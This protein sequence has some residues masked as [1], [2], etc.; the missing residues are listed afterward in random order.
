MKNLLPSEKIYIKQS[1]IPKAGRGI[2]A[3]DDIEKG[4]VIEV[5]PVIEISE[6]DASNVKEG[7]LTTYIYYSGKN[8]E[9]AL[10]ALGFGSIYNHTYA[11]NAQYRIN[12]AEQ[13]IT[14][15]AILDIKKDTE[16]TVNYNHE[17]TK[18][19]KPLWFE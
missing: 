4:E 9:K 12:D 5:C 2:Y 15:A 10:I 17:T 13:T 19:I 16:I 18:D 3:K 7:I 8:K 11:P 1:Q 6:H 14:F